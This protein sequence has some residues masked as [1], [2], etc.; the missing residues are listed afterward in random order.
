MN[1]I[2]ELIQIHE[3]NKEVLQVL[4]KKYDLPQLQPNPSDYSN[5][6]KFKEFPKIEIEP[7][8]R[9]GD[10][11]LFELFDSSGTRLKGYHYVRVTD[12]S[13]GEH[14][15]LSVPDKM[16]TCKEAIAW[17]FYMKSP[18]YHPLKET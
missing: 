12:S 17:T 18:E 2:E 10:Y 15:F 3:H 16:K 7:I 11:F 8:H 9:D 4:D 14:H 5:Y 13:T 6:I 1:E